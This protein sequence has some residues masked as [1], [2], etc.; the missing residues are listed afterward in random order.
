MHL[1]LRSGRRH[2]LVDPHPQDVTVEDLAVGL[3]RLARFGG[4][5]RERYS[6][7]QHSVLVAWLLQRRLVVPGATRL[8]PQHRLL[9]LA[10]LLHDAHEALWG[11][12]DIC[13][14]ALDAAP[15]HVRTW[16]E[17]HR[18]RHDVA[19]ALAFAL[20][21]AL[22]AHPDVRRVDDEA[23]T[24]ELRDLL[25][26]GRLAE[27]PITAR[28]EPVEEWH[29]RHAWL[30]AVRT[31]SAGDALLRPHFLREESVP[32][33]APVP[34]SP[35]TSAAPSAPAPSSPSS[36]PVTASCASAAPSAAP[37]PTSASTT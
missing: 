5:T 2:C 11:F 16:I 10:A 20:P 36:P 13:R 12:G 17:K 15:D 34:T 4:H 8:D 18:T 7:A 6:V 27:A 29:A 28:V 37:A 33:P 31:V 19:V 23:L 35:S 9:V 14:P 21:P 3:A 25:E 26:P 1:T 24:L 22:F 30:Y 32:C